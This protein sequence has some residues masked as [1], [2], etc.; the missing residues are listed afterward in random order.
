MTS[1]PAQAYDLDRS[2]CLALVG[3]RRIGR[4]VLGGD[5]PVVV[6]VNFAVRDEALIVR[7]EHDARAAHGVGSAVVFE[8]DD[9]DETRHAGWSVVIRGELDDVTGTLSI[10][11]E[12]SERLEPWAPGPKDRWLLVRIR[13]VSGRWVHGR[14]DRPPLDGR[15]YL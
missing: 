11:E 4:L 6:P 7:T 1:D 15:A 2:T 9:V 13:E 14:E 10:D 12:L 8:V 5:E 3:S